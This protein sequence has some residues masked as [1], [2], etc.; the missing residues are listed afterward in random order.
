MCTPLPSS[1]LP[2][3]AGSYVYISWLAPEGGCFCNSW[4]R[5]VHDGQIGQCVPPE[6]M[7]TSRNT[8]VWIFKRNQSPDSRFFNMFGHSFKNRPAWEHVCGWLIFPSHLLFMI[9]LLTLQKTSRTPTDQATIL[10][11]YRRWGEKPFQAVKR[12]FE[13][14]ELLR[15]L[16]N[17]KGASYF[18]QA[19]NTFKVL[20]LVHHLSVSNYLSSIYLTIFPFFPSF[21]LSVYPSTLELKFRSEICIRGMII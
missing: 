14:A 11:W 12:T 17:E 3:P 19:V 15:V 16:R 18:I 6:H 1:P 5:A 2:N 10:Q 21:P 8:Q 13:D 7:K 9:V 4:P 20:C